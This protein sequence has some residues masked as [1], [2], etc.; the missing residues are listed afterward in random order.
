MSPEAILR[1]ARR[2]PLLERTE[3]SNEVQIARHEIEQLLPHRDPMLL[4][5]RISAIDLEEQSIVGHR[6]IDPAD[7]IL[8]GHFPDHPVY[9]GA[10]LVEV[11]GQVSLCLNHFL[12]V[13]RTEVLDDDR[14]RSLRLMKVH[15][16][17]FLDEV[18]PDC[19]LEVLCRRLESDAFTATCV[20]QV[21]E[22]GRI[23]AIAMMDVYFLDEEPTDD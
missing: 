3:T 1:R 20:G 5:D 9:P 10:L 23:C 11:I 14:P 8:R 2:K 6:F 18:R 16:A 22:S 19:E 12:D 17:L 7:P 21:V 13:G 15:E 4:V